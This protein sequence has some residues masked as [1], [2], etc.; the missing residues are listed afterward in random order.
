LA[1]EFTWLVFLVV[2]HSMDHGE[3]LR[4]GIIPK[5]AMGIITLPQLAMLSPVVV[6]AQL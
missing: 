5:E 1:I 4:A 6:V 3:R 2:N